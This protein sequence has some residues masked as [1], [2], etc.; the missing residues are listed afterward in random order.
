MCFQKRFNDFGIEVLTPYPGNSPDLNSIKLTDIFRK[1]VNKIHQTCR[2]RLT[3]LD[4]AQ[5]EL[6]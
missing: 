1:R 2:I 4:S 5:M 3:G 6:L